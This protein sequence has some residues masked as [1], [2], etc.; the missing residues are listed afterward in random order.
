MKTTL[1]GV[2]W[3]MGEMARYDGRW[4]LT[5][6]IL[7]S[8]SPRRAA[9]FGPFDG[10]IA[11]IFSTLPAARINWQNYLGVTATQFDEI[12]ELMNAQINLLS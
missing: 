9:G 7:D 5:V 3:E 4:H 12:V 8:T 2:T 1:H 11:S 6:N 10:F